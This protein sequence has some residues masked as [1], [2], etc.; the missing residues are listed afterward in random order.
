M[1]KSRRATLAEILPVAKEDRD[2]VDY[3]EEA[4]P[5]R[6]P[7]YRPPDGTLYQAQTVDALPAEVR[8]ALRRH[9]EALGM[10]PARAAAVASL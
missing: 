3:S 9:L 1:M 6:D 4:I 8:L 7:A 10:S 5:E 2:S